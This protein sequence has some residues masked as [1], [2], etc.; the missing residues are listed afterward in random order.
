MTRTQKLNFFLILIS[1]FF[2]SSHIIHAEQNKQILCAIGL[3]SGTSMDGIDAALIK[4][5]G[6]Q[7]I[8]EAGDASLSY[9]LSF[10][11]LLKASEYI[12]RSHQGNMEKAYKDNFETA[13]NHYLLKVIGMKP[14]EASEI[15]KKASL[16]LK[17]EIKIITLNDVIQHSTQLHAQLIRD[18]LKK[19]GYKPNQIDVIGYHGQTFF[20]APAQK[21]T[22]QAGNG[23]TLA[24]EMGI[25]VVN[26]FRSA[27]VAN[28]G[29]GA[30]FA[31]LYHQALAMRDNLY[32]IVVVNCGGIANITLI[33][34]P[35]SKDL[36]AYD[37]GPGNGL[38]DLFVKR[39]TQ[40][41]E[42]MDL[43]GQYGRNG[44]VHM[45]I[46]QQLYDIS[47]NVNGQNY[48]KMLPPKSLDVNDMKLIQALDPLS[49]ED[50]CATLETFTAD[51]IVNSLSLLPVFQ[52]KQWVLA[53]GGWYNPVI[54]K[55]LQ[56]AIQKR[57]GNNNKVNMAEEIG[58]NNKTMEAQIFAYLAVRSLKKEPLSVPETT[59][60]SKPLSGGVIHVPENGRL[61]CFWIKPKI[62][63]TL[64]TLICMRDLC[65]CYQ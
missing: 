24:N 13:F 26:D 21:I 5:D 14:L 34:G 27:D 58:W 53:G 1:L 49:I 23:R 37:T 46:I 40:F 39:R 17:K 56:Y 38:V 48:F 16:Y 31:P 18:L 41:K 12:V 15:I 55:A 28:G 42:N 20:H 59:K 44:K 11:H 65:R 2:I 4:T 33:K 50:G 6:F 29:Q 43:D 54:K 3:M 36:I 22:I 19:I 57:F 47:I 64:P 7:H 25:V 10:H 35:N 51:A 61:R 8:E 60:V 32:P 9:D 45:P 52:P 62:S 63:K 30:P